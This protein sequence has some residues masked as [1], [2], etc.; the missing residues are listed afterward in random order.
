MVTAP[1]LDE[2]AVRLGVDAARLTRDGRA[3]QRLR[4]LR[5]RRTTSA[6][7][8]PPTTATT[9][10]RGAAR[11]PTSARSR[12][13]R[14]PPSRSCRATSAP[15][16]A[17]LTDEHAR[18]LRE[19]GTVDRGPLRGRQHL[20]VRDGPHLSRARARPSALRSS[21]A[22]SPPRARSPGR[23][24]ME[25]SGKVFVVTGG[26][27]GIGREVVLGL[28][29]RGAPRRRGRPQRRR[30]RRDRR[31]GRPDGS[32]AHHPRVNVTDAGAVAGASRSRWSTRTARST[33][34]S[35]SPASSSGSSTSPSWATTKSSGC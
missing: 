4:P 11:T 24:D 13:A 2:L 9:A 22:T 27:N 30:P 29:R 6:A 28:L 8:T 31:A 16:A 5:R 18:V 26:G 25:I 10:T 32:P 17:L 15:R 21:S 19:D 34:C 14:S 7:A 3:V 1:T 20:G 12:R 33:G 23:S 35:T